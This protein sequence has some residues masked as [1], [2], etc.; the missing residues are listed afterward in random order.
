MELSFGDTVISNWVETWCS[1]LVPVA[2]MKGLNKMGGLIIDARVETKSGKPEAIMCRAIEN[3]V[4]NDFME[5]AR[6]RFPNLA[7]KYIH[8]RLCM[9]KG[10]CTIHAPEGVVPVKKLNCTI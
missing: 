4:L 9:K 3:R 6:W 8:I 2:N 7:T 5:R 1:Q 10:W